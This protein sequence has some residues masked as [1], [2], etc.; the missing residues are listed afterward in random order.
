MIG[1][2]NTAP[3]YP[4]FG[5]DIKVRV[6]VGAAEL[7]SAAPALAR[8]C[9]RL[10]RRIPY[11]AQGIHFGTP[12]AR[13]CS[14]VRVARFDPHPADRRAG[15]VLRQWLLRQPH[16]LAHGGVPGSLIE[17]YRQ[18]FEH[19]G[20]GTAKDAIVGLGG[21][22]YIAKRSQDAFPR[23]PAA[24]TRRRCTGTGRRWRNSRRRR[25]CRWAARRR[26]STRR[27]PSM[28]RSATTSGSCSSSITPGFLSRRSSTSWSFSAGR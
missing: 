26:S 16:L 10:G 9:R 22:A 28:T 13:R 23:V 3:V 2:G 1:R 4:W 18:R 11:P 6:V 20:H 24:S 5:Q 8:G 15:R 12:P 25:R 17:F 19:H 21:H 7:R 27:S 14:A